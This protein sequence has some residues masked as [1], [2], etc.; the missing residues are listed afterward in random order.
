MRVRWI[1]IGLKFYLFLALFYKKGLNKIMRE[2]VIHGPL[3]GV[4]RTRI[5]CLRGVKAEGNN[6]YAFPS[7]SVV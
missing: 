3:P 1:M 4:H 2:P 7:L 6:G 5:L